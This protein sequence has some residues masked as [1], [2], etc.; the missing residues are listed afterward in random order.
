MARPRGAGEGYGQS[1]QPFG[2]VPST[3]TVHCGP[4]NTPEGTSQQI[5]P[6]MQHCV[7]QQNS[8]AGQ[9]TP[10]QG[11]VPQVPLSQ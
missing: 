5:V 6:C 4:V 2:H 9:A 1:G 7:P 8:D 3:G 11:G 10:L